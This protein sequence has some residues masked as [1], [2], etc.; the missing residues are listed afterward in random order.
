M[1]SP[2]GLVLSGGAACGLANVGVLEV[3]EEQKILP[4]CIAGSSMGA[5]VGGLWALGIPA[6][7]M[8]SVAL[9]LTMASVAAV[10]PSPLRNG[11]H[12]GILRQRITEK[13]EPL[14]GDA[15][16]ADCRIPFVCIAGKVIKPI[17]WQGILREGFT[18]KAME[19]VSPHVFD[20]HTRVIDAML[21]SSAIPVVF[22]PVVVGTEEFIDLCHFGAVPAR[23]LRQRCHPKIVIATCTDPRMEGLEKILPHSWRRFIADGVAEMNRSL[24]VCDL[25]I[26]PDIPAS[27]FRF[28][29]AEVFIEAGRRAAEGGLQ[30]IQNLLG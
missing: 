12:G 1:H 16:I 19:S 10:S 8:R 9:D 27:P 28:D 17:R 22:S 4:S 15:T 5:I 3:L 18:E 29:K 7:T 20:G 26:R 30:D 24:E 11:L 21:A 14:I 13:L 25:V 2:F 23:T 6:K